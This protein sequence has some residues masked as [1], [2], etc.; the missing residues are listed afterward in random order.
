MKKTKELISNINFTIEKTDREEFDNCEFSN[1]VFGELKRID[2]TDCVF[3]NC[4][5]S[6]AYFRNCK[7]Q[8]I[9]FID[10]KLIGA[11]FS[12][13]ADFGF[14]ITCES[15]NLDYTSFDKKKINKSGFKNCKMHGAN[16]T[17]ADLSKA[18]LINCDFA[19][20]LFANTNVSGVDF[21]TSKNFLID[22][23]LNNIKKAKFLSQDLHALLY[24]YDIIIL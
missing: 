8:D 20:A 12:Q 2:F 23:N 1:C 9:T 17:Q 24:R 13:V 7:L 22:P 16:F 11:N 10:C 18:S 14:C 6:N 19:D 4:N 3:K 21:T 15:C 5:L